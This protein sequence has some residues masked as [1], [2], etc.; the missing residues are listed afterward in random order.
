M[1]VDNIFLGYLAL[2]QA[3]HWHVQGSLWVLWSKRDFA[4]LFIPYL[5]MLG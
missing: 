4:E 2:R 5:I 1:V 3:L